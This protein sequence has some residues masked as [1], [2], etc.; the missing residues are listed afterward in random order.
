[1]DCRAG[2]GV[3]CVV[4]EGVDVD[5]DVVSLWDDLAD[6][7]TAK[8]RPEAGWHD[9]PSMELRAWTSFWA[10]RLSDS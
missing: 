7:K 5:V 8:D 2:H 6:G 1:L 10:R 9:T 3:I 4:D